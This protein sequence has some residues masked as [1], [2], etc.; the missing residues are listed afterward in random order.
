MKLP[1]DPF[2]K[3]NNEQKPLYVVPFW[4]LKEAKIAALEVV[5]TC[6][7]RFDKHTW[8]ISFPAFDL[9]FISESNTQWKDYRNVIDVAELDEL[10]LRYK[11]R[12]DTE[13]E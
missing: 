1:N 4:T 6:H 11:E 7:L 5:Q 10:L 12:K 8:T 2:A 13:N 9:R 3:S